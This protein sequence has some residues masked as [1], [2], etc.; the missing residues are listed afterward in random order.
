[1]TSPT[2]H[3]VDGRVRLDLATADL[4][5][6]GK[7][8]KLCLVLVS[9]VLAEEKLGSRRQLGAYP[10]CGTAAVAAV[11]SRQLGTCCQSCV[12]WLLRSLV[13]TVSDVRRF[14]VVPRSLSGV[15][16]LTSCKRLVSSGFLEL[17]TV[18]FPPELLVHLCGADNW[19]QA[20]SR[21]EIRPDTAAGADFIHLSTPEQVHLPANRLFRGRQ[22]LVL[23]HVDPALLDSPLRWEPGV[24]TDPEAMLFPHLYGPLPVAAVTRVTVYSPDPGGAFAPI[25][26]VRGSSD[27]AT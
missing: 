2:P 18:T 14:C 24:P 15:S 13:F 5:H 23:L 22:D 12:H 20:Q 6:G 25:A 7:L 26:G 11:G 17:S 8:N 1:M 3:I 27:D 9:V 21:G 4:Q 10:G 19:S 16:F